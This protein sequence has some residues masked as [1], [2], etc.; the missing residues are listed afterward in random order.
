MTPRGIPVGVL[1]AGKSFSPSSRALLLK[2]C[3][4]KERKDGVRKLLSAIWQCTGFEFLN[5]HL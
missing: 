4:E 5:I 3:V 1:K 2:T